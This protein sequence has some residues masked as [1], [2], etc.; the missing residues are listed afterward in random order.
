MFADTTNKAV[1]SGQDGWGLG[2]EPE[3]RIL[4]E[5]PGGRQPVRGVADLLLLNRGA[6]S[7]TRRLVRHSRPRQN[8]ELTIYWRSRSRGLALGS[9]RR[10][11]QPSGTSSVSKLYSSVKV[12]RPFGSLAS[13]KNPNSYRSNSL[14]SCNFSNSL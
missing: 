11:Y 7:A 3:F 10:A 14:N 8:L 12:V 9:A 5:A 1:G 13:T 6:S 2:E 4:V